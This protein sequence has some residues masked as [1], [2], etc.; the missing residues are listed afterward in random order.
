MLLYFMQGVPIGLAVIALPA[1]LAAN[2]ARPVEIGAFVGFA[3]LPWSLKP[4]AGLVMDRFTYRPMGRRRV[5]ILSAQ[6]AMA[7][8]LIAL[9]VTAPDASQISALSA[10]CFA[11]NMC[12]I[13]N[14][15]AV[16]GMTIDIVPADEHG[17]INGYM[18]GSQAVGVAATSFLAGSLYAD[19][20]GTLALFLL[21]AM[22]AV[23]PSRSGPFAKGPANG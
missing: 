12:A 7:T 5:W 15:V 2:G 8:T 22:V 10:F 21:A 19:G 4:L 1:W 9:G 23:A 11:L 6:A 20:E 13:L 18:F 3:V 16:D 17:A 14:D